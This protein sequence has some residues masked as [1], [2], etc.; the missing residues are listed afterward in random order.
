MSRN[1][2]GIATAVIE[3]IENPAVNPDFFPRKQIEALARALLVAVET[4][5]AINH[6]VWCKRVERW[7]EE[8]FS[9]WPCP[10][11]QA[12]EALARIRGEQP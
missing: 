1:A 7:N 11:C 9:A 3:I 6:H 12:R 5:G 4:L 2:E 10:T 8:T